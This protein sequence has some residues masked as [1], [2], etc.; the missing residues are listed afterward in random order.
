MM[1][2]LL[3]VGLGGGAGSILRYLISHFSLKLFP[4]NYPWGTFL[5]NIAGCL[6]IGI[7]LGL[8]EK[9]R[10]LNADLK[11]LL[12]VGFCGGFT[13]FST[14]AAENMRLF[15]SGHLATAFLYTAASVL[16]G[17]AAVWSGLIM[18]K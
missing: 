13:T 17:L 9:E 8:F 14:F 15:Q 1:K 18:V 10:I 5:V 4:G 3:Y 16:L 2:A 11:Y 6:L 12:I 7:L